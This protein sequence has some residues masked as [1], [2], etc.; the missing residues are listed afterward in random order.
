MNELSNSIKDAKDEE[1]ML[2]ETKNQLEELNNVELKGDLHQ[3]ME[4]FCLFEQA[5]TKLD[6]ILAN[7]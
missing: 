1:K 6:C 3:I 2:V 7:L 5:R 4:V